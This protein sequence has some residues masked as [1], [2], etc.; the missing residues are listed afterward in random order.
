[1][2]QLY[3]RYFRTQNLPHIFCAGCG[4]G[5]IMGALVRAMDEVGVDPDRTVVVSGIGCSSR[6]PGYMNFDTLHTTH[7]RALAFATGVKMARPELRVL[8]VTGD[9]DLSAIGGN[10]LIHAARRNIDI[11]TVCFNNSIYGM[12]GGQYSPMTPTT[13]RAT[14]SPYGNVE[15]CFD[16]CELAR[17]AGSTYVGRGTAYHVRVMIRVLAEALQHQG[18]SFVEA[19]SQCPT[20]FGRRNRQTTVKSMLE[21]QKDHAVTVRQAESLTDEAM[22]DRFVIGQIYRGEAPEYVAAYDQLAA[23]VREGG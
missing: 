19:V 16:L 13:S 18:F 20:Y 3:E 23:R 8:V 10:H 2:S 5:T 12:T 7:G 11:T 15:R 4:H 17:A 14:T 22:Q 6:I 9:G 21:W 1:M